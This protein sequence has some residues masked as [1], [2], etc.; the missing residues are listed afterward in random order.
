MRRGLRLVFKALLIN[1][2]MRSSSCVRGRPGRSSSCSPVT[3][4]CRYRRRQKL[5]SATLVPIWAAICVLRMPP[6]DNSTIRARR[7]MPFGSARDWA[8]P[9]SCSFSFSDSTSGFFGRPSRTCPMEPSHDLPNPHY[10]NSY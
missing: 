8:M 10:Y 4:C 5:T 9:R 2:A 7:T 3:P 1:A 6:A